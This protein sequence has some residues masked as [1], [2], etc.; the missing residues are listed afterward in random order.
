VR[1]EA[2]DEFC[3]AAEPDRRSANGECGMKRPTIPLQR[4]PQPDEHAL[5]S[6]WRAATPRRIGEALDCSQRRD[7]SGW[8][9]AGAS[10][11]VG[12]RSVVRT[13][14]GREVALWRGAEGR[15]HAGPG[16]CPHLDA[17]LHGCVIDGDDVLCRWHGM[18]LPREAGRGW[19]E[20]PA[21][22]DGVLFWVR[23][24][25]PGEELSNAPKLPERPPLEA[26][27]A[28]VIALPAACEPRDIIANRLDPWHGAWFHP[29]AFS[30]LTVDEAASTTERLVVDVAF[31]LGRTWG[32]PVRAEFTT[33][34]ARTIVMRITEGEG[35]GSV[36][37]THATPLAPGPDGRP[38]T[39]M[40]EATIAYSE[41]PGFRAAR[42]VGRGIVPLIR[43][44]A[45]ALWVDDLAYAE[46]TYAVR[47][48]LVPGRPS[49]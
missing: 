33:P 24:P 22:D 46:R 23:L 42:A 16:A 29:Y 21:H 37:E 44:T 39:M 32:V 10:T 36:V 34:D 18:A 41:R 11:D 25:T 49:P 27:I 9:V 28:A 12:D 5:R 6:T 15:P 2:I 38:R 17:R 40:T 35:A 14:A 20:Y 1:H 3:A 48:G 31:R 7:P 4:L 47:A 45:R 13:L 26:S 43:R 30:H 8:Y 19:R